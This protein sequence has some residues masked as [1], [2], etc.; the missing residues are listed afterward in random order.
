MRF[1]RNIKVGAL[2]AYL[3]ITYNTLTNHDGGFS[4]AQSG[5]TNISI[6]VPLTTLEI[7]SQ[8]QSRKIFGEAFKAMQEQSALNGTSEMTLDEINDAISECRRES[9]EK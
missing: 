1:I 9:S 4:M 8:M 2:T 6:R 7:D 3:K 5:M